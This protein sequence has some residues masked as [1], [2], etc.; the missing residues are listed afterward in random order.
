MASW[1]IYITERRHQIDSIEI[2]ARSGSCRESA[3]GVVGTMNAA[4]SRPDLLATVQSGR[5]Q[6]QSRVCT[7]GLRGC[8]CG[9]LATVTTRGH[10]CASALPSYQL[11]MFSA[12]CLCSL[13]RH[14]ALLFYRLLL[15]DSMIVV[16]SII[17]N[18]PI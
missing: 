16:A 18:I 2:L 6:A 4:R 8:S 15:N 1:C 13:R 10:H 3:R 14:I 17:I 5:K 9:S 7:P 11:Y 12:I